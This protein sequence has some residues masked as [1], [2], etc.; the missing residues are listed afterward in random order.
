[1]SLGNRLKECLIR[2]KLALKILFSPRQKRFEILFG[3]RQKSFDGHHMGC[4]LTWPEDDG[5]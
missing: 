2:V 3:P 1:M 4:R 5:T